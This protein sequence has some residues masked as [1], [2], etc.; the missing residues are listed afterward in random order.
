MLTR[1]HTLS[2]S[3]SL[4]LSHTLSLSQSLFIYLYLSFSPSIYI[5]LSISLSLPLALSLSRDQLMTNITVHTRK[6]NSRTARGTN[7]LAL[8][9][10]TE[11]W[12]RQGARPHV[13]PCDLWLTCAPNGCLATHV[14]SAISRDIV[15]D[16][17]WWRR[18]SAYWWLVDRLGYTLFWAKQFCV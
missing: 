9:S 8:F 7:T 13:T 17:H 3:L 4:S 14:I 1:G 18:L 6:Y 16:G 5:Y 12:F 11:A 15:F 10:V 2:L